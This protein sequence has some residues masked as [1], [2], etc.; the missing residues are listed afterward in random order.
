ME[1][2]QIVFDVDGTLVNTEYA[3]LHSFRDTL[4]A[5]PKSELPLKTADTLFLDGKT[6]IPLKN[7]DFALG[8]T[9]ADA[10]QKLGIK[11]IPGVLEAWT[12]NLH[13]YDGYTDVFDGMEEVL[14]KLSKKG[15]E[16]G[17]IT[18]RTVDEFE[19]DFCNLHIRRYFKTVI[20]A[21]DTKKHKP[22]PEPL[23]AYME[24]TQTERT[25]VLYIGDSEY[26]SRCASNAG[27][28]FALAGWGCKNPAIPAK[29]RLKQ[30][31]DLVMLL[32]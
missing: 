5:L 10:L 18:S 21:D 4:L 6:D 2:K 17:I 3:V 24:K 15:Y 26:D 1:Y 20:C 19:Y 22:D 9:G 23:F 28:D 29:Y 14:E 8:I 25:Q 11:N 12:Q 16:M 32:C 27:V 31:S 13:K 7:L 30:P